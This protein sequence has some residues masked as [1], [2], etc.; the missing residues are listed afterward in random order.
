M[1]T[2]KISNA[3]LDLHQE[4]LNKK[5]LVARLQVDIAAAQ[6]MLREMKKLINKNTDEIR[7]LKRRAEIKEVAH[8]DE[9]AKYKKRLELALTHVGSRRGD[10]NKVAFRQHTK[11]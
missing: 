9:I 6:Q 5:Q 8:T 3:A 1:N 11:D 10:D 2:Q 4:L 7:V